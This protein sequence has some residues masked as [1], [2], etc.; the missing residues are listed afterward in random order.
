MPAAPEPL[1]GARLLFSLDPGVSYLNH[2]TV[3]V[4]PIPVQ[5]AHQR[6]RDEMESDPQRFYTRG[7][8]ERLAHAPPDLARVLGADPDRPAPVPHKTDGAAPLL[9]PLPP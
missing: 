5:R 4:T 8:T 3:G 2:G 7:R 6:L 9:H 1:P